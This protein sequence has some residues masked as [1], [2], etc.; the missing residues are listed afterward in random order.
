MLALL[1][2]TVDET[3]EAFANAYSG[4]VSLQNLVP[5]AAAARCSSGRHDAPRRAGAL[6]DRPVSYQSFLLLLGSFFVP[7]FAVLLADWLATRALDH[8]ADVFDTPAW[9]P[10]ALAAWVAGFAVYQWLAPTGPGWWVD[11]VAHIDPPSWGIGATLPCFAV[12]LVLGLAA[13]AVRRPAP[14]TSAG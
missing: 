9:R 12:S 11:L 10:G 3:D 6:V 13:V 2:L 1:A 14:R 7:L 5:G 4:A 8:R